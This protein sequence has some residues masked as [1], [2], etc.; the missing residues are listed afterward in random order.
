[1]KNKSEK[2]EQPSEGELEILQIL[3]EIEPATVKMIHEKIS[4]NK[5]VGYTTTLKQIQR[6]FDKRLVKRI[7]EGKSHLYSSVVG[8]HETQH[9]LF[10]KVMN[11]AFGGSALKM[12]MHAIDK[13]KVS[14]A[15]LDEIKAFINKLAGDRN[16]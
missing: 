14:K 11:S 13:G 7:K 4:V 16:E 6:M 9:R 3:W 8:K 5:T 12:A 15:E 2:S 1:M 10:D